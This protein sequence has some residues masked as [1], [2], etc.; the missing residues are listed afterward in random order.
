MQKTMPKQTKTILGTIFLVIILA[1]LASA[2]TLKSVSVDELS[3]GQEGTIRIEIENEL[4]D[5]AKSLSFRLDLTNLPFNPIGN[6]EDS[7][8]EL[9]EGDD[10]EFIFRIKSANDISPGDY[11]IPYTITYSINNVQTTRQGAIGITVKGNADLSFSIETEKP[12]IGMQ[13]KI[14]LKIINKGFADARF[15]S[16]R[17]NLNGMTILSDKDVYIGTID[18][19]DFETETFN[20]I[21]KSQNPEFSA[22]IEYKDFDNKNII[23]IISLPVT[24]YSQ[25]KALEL[26]LIQKNNA[27]VYI[28]IIIA[29]IVIWFLYRTIKKSIK[30]KRLNN[31]R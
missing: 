5:D 15:V 7:L 28:G 11:K 22:I 3:P 21:Y 2:I 12:I 18:S 26:G 16:V 23:K 27:P 20:V 17:I 10:E 13:D 24:V 9:N 30:R 19:D 31:K 1:N 14:T 29:L 4:N 8:D 25:E 6:S